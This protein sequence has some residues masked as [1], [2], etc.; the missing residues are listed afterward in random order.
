MKAIIFEA[1]G[2]PNV[3]KLGEF[4]TPEPKENELL[5]KVKAIALN[6]ADT[7]QRKGKY[8]PPAGASPILGLEIAGV[9]TNTGKKVTKWD[10]GN[11]I[12]G[13][14]P[15]GGYAEYAVINEEMAMPVP[16]NLSMHE[17]AAI[18]E[19]FLTAYQSL[20]WYGKL[21]KDETVLIHAGASGVGTAAIQ[22]AS[23]LGA[24]IVVTAS[25]QKHQACI[26][27]GAEMTIDY[28]SESFEKKILEFTNGKGAD[29]IIDFIG[30]PYFN[31]DINSL[32]IDGMLIIL[33]MLGGGKVDEFDL[34]KL[35]SKRITIL[36][37]TLRSRKLDYQIKLTK[38]FSEFALKKFNLGKL[39]PVIDSIFE[40]DK[41]AEAHKYMEENKNIGKI[42]LIV[43]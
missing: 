5:V 38:E 7:L 18:P 40:W 2:E 36:G 14:I 4:N 11:E 16:N 13:L 29:L 24:K 21:K 17:A 27:L 41:V 35:L 8:P 1:P 25:K 15:G 26:N 34:K 20:I 42:V 9:V 30:G 39:H 3:L 19:A 12:F 23:E 33:A 10:K 32:N 43:N 28:K 22:I 37:S 31:Q 6:R